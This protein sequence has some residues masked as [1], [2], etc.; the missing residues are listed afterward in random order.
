MPD[1]SPS[2]DISR[3]ADAPTVPV[4]GWLAEIRLAFAFLTCLPVR[5]KGD[6]ATHP[7]GAAVRA[8]PIAGLVIG[9]AGT[10]LYALADLFGLSSTIAALLAIGAMIVMS[11]GLHEDGLADAADGLGGRTRERAL[12][13]MRDSHIGSFGV[14]ALVLILSLRVTALS[15]AGSTVEAAVMLVAAASGS[16]AVVPALM[17]LL[18]PARADGLGWAAGHPDR[19]RVVDAG[20]LGTLFVVATLGPIWGLIAVAAAALAGSIIGWIAHRRFGGQTGDVLGAGQQISEAAILLA[21]VASPT[22]I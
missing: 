9:I 15:Y 2:P 18:P 14:I 3:R 12:A 16:R 19:R 22:W 21:Y 20:A 13:I 10:V 17:Y 11:G 7:V 1:T 8:F 6:E 5:L 4:L